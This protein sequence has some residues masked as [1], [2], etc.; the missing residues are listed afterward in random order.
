[1]EFE[2]HPDIN[3]TYT[4]ILDTHKK[5]RIPNVINIDGCECGNVTHSSIAKISP[6]IG[7]IINKFLFV[8]DGLF[9]S[10]ENSLIASAKGWGSPL[11][12]TLFGPLRS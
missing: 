2:H 11:K 1:M 4:F 3:V 7:V 8:R 12:D 9:C 10:L 5:Y 6:V